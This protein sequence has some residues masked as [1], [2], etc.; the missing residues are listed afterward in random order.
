MFRQ[1]EVGGSRQLLAL[2]SWPKVRATKLDQ[3]PSQWVT[4]RG[5]ELLT[6]RLVVTYIMEDAGNMVF[7]LGVAN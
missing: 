2:T 7:V 6:V 5:Q 3:L 4:P 1:S